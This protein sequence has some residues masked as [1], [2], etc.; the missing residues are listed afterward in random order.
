[1]FP[2]PFLGPTA[3]E[4]W[5]GAALLQAAALGLACS[6]TT[7]SLHSAS[8]PCV[9]PTAEVSREFSQPSTVVPALHSS[10][11][12]LSLPVE[13]CAGAGSTAHL[14]RVWV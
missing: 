1:M 2:I 9:H 12:V 6:L 4:G 11:L 13:G 8:V 7:D 10:G 3:T 14:G 5:W